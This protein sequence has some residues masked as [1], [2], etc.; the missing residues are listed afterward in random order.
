MPE[1]VAQASE[2]AH[3]MSPAA[4]A[5]TANNASGV[6]RRAVA[7][8]AAGMTTSLGAIGSSWVYPTRDGP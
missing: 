4:N 6:M 1:L 3:R 2:V 5:L 7:I 8:S